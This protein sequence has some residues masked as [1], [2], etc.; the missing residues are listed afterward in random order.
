MN[1][2]I[3]VKNIQ[4]RNALQIHQEN[5]VIYCKE[6]KEYYRWQN[7]EYV[8]V[9]VEELVNGALQMNYRDLLKNSI[10]GLDPFTKQQYLNTQMKIDE[11]DSQENKEFYMLYCKE[12][13]Y[14]T[15]FRRTNDENNRCLSKEVMLCL[16]DIGDLLYVEEI[17][18]ETPII[19]W[20]KAKEEELITEVY[21]FDY[22]QGVV[23]FI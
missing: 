19:F 20:I 14:F 22:T 8:L 16:S 21:L 10:S 12:I 9:D 18:N 5:E 11:W 13:N 4:E 2:I 6:E 7:N 17:D 3:Q 1:S 23:P 15:L